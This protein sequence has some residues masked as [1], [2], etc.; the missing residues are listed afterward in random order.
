MDRIPS[1]AMQSHEHYALLPFG[2]I[3]IRSQSVIRPSPHLI[4]SRLSIPPSTGSFAK[5]DQSQEAH[6]KSSATI[7]L[8]PS[9]T[10]QLDRCL[11]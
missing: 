2:L 1:T 8:I 9:L 11:A 3:V 4:S 10:G 7:F 6:L 5:I